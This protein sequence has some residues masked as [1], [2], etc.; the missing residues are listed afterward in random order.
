MRKNGAIGVNEQIGAIN[1]GQKSPRIEIN[2][3]LSVEKVAAEILSFSNRSTLMTF[4][5]HNKRAA[6][7]Y[8]DDVDHYAKY[9]NSVIPTHRCTM[10]KLHLHSQNNQ[11]HMPFSSFFLFPFLAKNWSRRE[12]KIDIGGQLTLHR[13]PLGLTKRH[14]PRSA[15]FNYRRRTFWPITEITKKRQIKY[16]CTRRHLEWHQANLS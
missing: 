4:Q 1:Y 2:P 7:L 15:V 14:N 5:P 6:F 16:F 10:S 12:P 11:F 3:H 13:N 8:M 9:A